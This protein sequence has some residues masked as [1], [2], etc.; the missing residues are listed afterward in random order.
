MIIFFKYLQKGRGDAKGS[1]N[2]RERVQRCT[3]LMT[4]INKQHTDGYC[5]QGV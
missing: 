5:I 2:D 4:C 3:I 1:E